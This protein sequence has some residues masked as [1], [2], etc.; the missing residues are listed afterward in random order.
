MARPGESTYEIELIAGQ[1]QEGIGDVE[2]NVAEVEGDIAI[3]EAEVA[4]LAIA[5]D[6]KQVGLQFKDE[7]VDL[8]GPATVTTI[9]FTGA[10][11]T[12]TRVGNAITVN[13]P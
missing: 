4:G 11:V 6:G 12:V 10:G 1:S 13:I 9:D 5:V 7:G 2:E 3:L 8:G